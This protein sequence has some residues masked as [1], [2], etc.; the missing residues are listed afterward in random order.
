MRFIISCNKFKRT[1]SKK[2]QEGKKNKDQNLEI[3][4]KR[5]RTR[6]KRNNFL[7]NPMRDK[8]IY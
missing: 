1:T 6:F 8:K 5:R 7:N 3:K 2:N 4:K